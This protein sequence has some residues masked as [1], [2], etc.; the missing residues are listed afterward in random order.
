MSQLDPVLRLGE[1]VADVVGLQDV[2]GD[3]GLNVG[4]DVVGL[5][6]TKLEKVG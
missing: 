4:L 2:G 1:V 5:D 3:V 6:L